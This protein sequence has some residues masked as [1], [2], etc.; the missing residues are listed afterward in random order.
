[1][2]GNGSVALTWA[3]P[4]SNGGAAVVDHRVQYSSNNGVSW[5]TFTGA[6]TAVRTATVT[7]LTNGVAYVFRVAALNA[8]GSGGST[9]KSAA[10]TPRTVPG[11]PTNL[12][13]TPVTGRVNLAWRAPASNGGAAITDYIVQYSSN[14]GTTWRIFVESVSSATSA[15]VTGLVRGTS[16][17]FRVVAMNVAGAGEYSAKTQA[18]VAR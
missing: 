7:G 13:A 5:T 1:M 12:T 17:V 6:T 15:S 18:V 4:A 11:G 2:A 10:V 14:N 9:A 8:A 16:Y 3:A